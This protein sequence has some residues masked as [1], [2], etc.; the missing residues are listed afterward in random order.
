MERISYYNKNIKVN[1]KALTEVYEILQAYEDDIDEIPKKYMYVIEDNMDK[2]YIFSTEDLENIELLEDT[3]KILTYL[4][5]NFLST[6]EERTVLKQI[7]K[8]QYE[9]VQK[10][11]NISYDVFEKRQ[12]I[13]NNNQQENVDL[14]LTVVEK[15]NIFT[16]IIKFIKNL[17]KR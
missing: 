4:Y 15:Q 13:T 8:I 2:D 7:E 5:T 9:K 16:K 10:E 12:I 1:R 11:S 6:P 3:K 14:H 17:F